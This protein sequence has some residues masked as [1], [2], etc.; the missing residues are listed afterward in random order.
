MGNN[1]LENIAKLR[2]FG[3]VGDNTNKGGD[4]CLLAATNSIAGL[5]ATTPTR[6]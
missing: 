4:F 6:A 1:C 3:F 5:L 2:H